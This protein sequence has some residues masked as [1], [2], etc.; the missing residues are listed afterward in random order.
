MSLTKFEPCVGDIRMELSWEWS[1]VIDQL[2]HARYLWS[3]RISLQGM[4]KSENLTHQSI[5]Q[6]HFVKK[7]GSILILVKQAEKMVLV[8][9][10]TK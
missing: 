5:M 1:V 4:T 7:N 3:C 6:F 2:Y 9:R 10:E 8:N